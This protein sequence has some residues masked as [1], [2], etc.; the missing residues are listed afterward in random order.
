[1]AI[2]PAAMALTIEEWHFL[3]DCVNDRLENLIDLQ[4]NFEPNF[5]D[6]IHMAKFILSCIDN[7]M[8]I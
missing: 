2:A 4:E 8:G 7:R 1:M 5:A 3:R 6:D